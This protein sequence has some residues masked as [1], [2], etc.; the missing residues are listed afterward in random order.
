MTGRLGFWALVGL[1]LVQALAGCTSFGANVANSG[2]SSKAAAAAAPDAAASGVEQRAEYRLEIAAPE[3]LRPLLLNYLDLARF[4]NAPVTDG[5]TSAELDRLIAAAPAQVRAL[6]ETEGYFNP[7]VNVARVTAEASRPTL[8]LVEA[9][10]GTFASTLTGG[11]ASAAAN[12]PLLRVEVD[13]GPRATITQVSFDVSGAL[14][15]AVLA[16]DSSAIDKLAAL[17]KDWPLPIGQPFRQSSWSGAKT[18]TLARLR[19]EG[20]A[21]A[22]WANTA[23]KIDASNQT[24]QLTLLIDSGPLFRLG[25]IRIEG[26]ERYDEDSVRRLATFG[27]GTPYDDK[28]L[29]DYQER[30]QKLGLFEGAFIE[31]D[32]NPATASAAPVLVRV[33][34]LPL[35]TATFG[36][37]YSAN[38]GP[39]ITFEH[40]HRRVFG[41]RWVA[42][43]KFE[44]G[45]DQKLWSGELISHPLEGLYRNLVAGSAE[46]L[47]TTDELRTSWSARIGRTQDTQRIERLYYAEYVSARLLTASTATNSD[48]RAI[49][50]NYH[51]VFRNLDSALL[52]TQGYSLSA[53]TALGLARSTTADNGPFGRAYARLTGYW[54]LGASWYGTARVEAGQVFAKDSVGVPD[55]LLFRAGGDESVRGYAYRALGPLVGG[56]VT[57]GRMLLTGSIEVARPLSANRPAFWWA[58]FADAGNASNRWSDFD[59]A[60]GYGIGLRWRSPVGPLRLDLAYG[61]QVHAYR[62]HLSVGIA[63]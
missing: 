40:L 36:A 28:L 50:G 51:W 53:Q 16:Q 3:A 26:L 14:N 24:V 46:R 7:V 18:S 31:I 4:Q 48:S 49:S 11:S 44:F 1:L 43:N 32:P 52:P 2:G 6:L 21:A 47:R 54:P 13:P 62:V 37:G 29:L 42:K 57:S 58:V 61:Q 63:F 17:R 22:T 20:Y 19:S 55:T 33:K 23:A 8:K 27:E 9:F 10:V 30:L 59:P 12:T 45:P 35:Q 15:D 25:A 5:I 39:R 41:T 38:T 34:E 56:V 60:T